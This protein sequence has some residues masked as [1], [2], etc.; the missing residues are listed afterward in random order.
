MSPSEHYAIL[1]LF[2]AGIAHGVSCHPGGSS[3]AGPAVV[4]SL[5]VRAS[6]RAPTLFAKD[7]RRNGA[8]GSGRS[9]PLGSRPYSFAI[10]DVLLIAF[11]CLG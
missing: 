3:P 11:A 6:G 2:L 9:H 7:T 5:P 1:T 4:L 8:T 10:T